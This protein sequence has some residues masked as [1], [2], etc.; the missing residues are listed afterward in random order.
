M[1]RHFSKIVRINDFITSKERDVRRKIQQL[2]EKAAKRGWYQTGRKVFIKAANPF[3]S[4]MILRVT[5]KLWK[6][7]NLQHKQRV[8]EHNERG[9]F[10]YESS[11]DDFD[12]DHINRNVATLRQAHGED[13]AGGVVDALPETPGQLSAEERNKLKELAIEENKVEEISKPEK[14]KGD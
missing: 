11:I 14:D 8:E 2:A 9:E 3:V 4:L 12:Q 6:K 13:T 7:Y 10:N 1:R 5:I